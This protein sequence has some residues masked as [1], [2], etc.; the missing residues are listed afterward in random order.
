VTVKPT[1]KDR[2][3]D[4]LKTRPGLTDREIADILQG[5]HAGQ[6]AVNPATRQLAA[7]GRIVRQRR[8][9]GLFRNY[10][11]GTETADLTEHVPEQ[12]GDSKLVAEDA[13]S[14][15]EVKEA[16]EAWLTADGWH[17]TVMF[18]HD[19]GIDVDARRDK[20]RWIIEAKG[21]G[22]YD[23][24]RVNYFLG[25]LGELLRRMDDP[26]ARYSIALPDLAQCR[27]LWDRL[28]E[29]AKQRMRLSALFVDRAGQVQESIK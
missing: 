3:L 22:K 21:A 29:L 19:R 5:R 12:P 1:L 15:D 17:V 7:N 18:G 23:P 11:P 8:R 26:D 28:P 16:L 14:E 10:L 27:R 4:L 13:M 20:S 9:D 24:M 6:Q 25:A 2:I